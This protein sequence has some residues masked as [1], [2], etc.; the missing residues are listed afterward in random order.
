MEVRQVDFRD[1]VEDDSPLYRVCFWS[2]PGRVPEGVPV[3]K[4]GFHA[5]EYEISDARSVYE[6]LAWAEAHSGPERTF[7]VYVLPRRNLD[8]DAEWMHRLAGVDPTNASTYGTQPDGYSWDSIYREGGRQEH[9][10]AD[11]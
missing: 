7:C 5:T 11:A 4:L 8:P 2:R 1:S 3:E 10:G 6:V 9:F